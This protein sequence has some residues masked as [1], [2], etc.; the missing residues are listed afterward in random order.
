[1]LLGVSKHVMRPFSSIK[2]F[3]HTWNK[4]VQTHIKI[5]NLDCNYLAARHR[6]LGVHRHTEDQD[7]GHTHQSVIYFSHC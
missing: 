3:L 7:M 5:N 1:M 6:R 4:V 2:Y